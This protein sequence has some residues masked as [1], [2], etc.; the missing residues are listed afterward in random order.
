VDFDFNLIGV[1]FG[2]RPGLRRLEPAV[3]QL[4]R[5]DPA[6]RLCREKHAVW[7]AGASRHVVAGFDPAPALR[8]IADHA[9]THGLDDERRQLDAGHPPE[10]AFEEDLAVLDG[11]TGTLPWLGVCVPSHWAPEDKVGLD[12]A[13]LHGPVADNAALLAASQ[14]LVGLVTGGA[15]WERHVW[16]IS[17]SGR[18]DQHPR[19]QARTAWPATTD[20]AAFAAQCWFRAERQTFFPVGQGTRQAVFTIRLMLQPLAQAVAVAWQA[21]RLYDALA[22][23]SDAVLAYKNLGP[24]REPLLRWLETKA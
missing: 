21:R 6:S 23:M 7:A 15:C 9:A 22:S 20:A 14:H 4:T 8:A 3:P 19:R 10:L 13:A 17:P 2:M 12:F 18:H 16:T 5:L 1:P 11:A 24:A